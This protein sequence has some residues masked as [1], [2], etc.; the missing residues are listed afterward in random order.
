[1]DMH[2]HQDPERDE[3]VG[4][5]ASPAP[6]G[7]PGRR[8]AEEKTQA[9]LELLSGKTTVDSLARRFGVREQTVE[10]WRQEAVASIGAAMRQGDGK[11]ASERALEKELHGLK[12]AFTDLAIRHELV[13]QALEA[14][15]PSQPRRSAK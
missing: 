14:R 1:M 7:R 10:Q 11:S 5:E 15:P 9:V 2:A 8:S 3:T 6:R 13:K 4:G 12:K